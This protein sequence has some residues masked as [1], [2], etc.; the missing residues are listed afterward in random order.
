MSAEKKKLGRPLKPEMERKIAPLNIRCT[1]LMRA[2]IEAAAA[3]SGRSMAAEATY[4][5]EMGLLH[6][7]ISAL[8]HSIAGAL[9]GPDEL[10]SILDEL[11]N[12]P[13]ETVQ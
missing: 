7:D 13:K 6:D 12:S 4:R 10:A 9:V 3:Q 5:M 1:P 11:K 2:R 8:L